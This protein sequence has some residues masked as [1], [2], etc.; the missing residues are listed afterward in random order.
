MIIREAY[1]YEFSRLDPSGAHIDTVHVAIYENVMV[2]GPDWQAHPMLAD[3]WTVS[4]AA[5]AELTDMDKV[6][7]GELHCTFELLES[8]KP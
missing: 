6:E 1:D 8:L 3:R 4:E 5:V 2:K 7:R